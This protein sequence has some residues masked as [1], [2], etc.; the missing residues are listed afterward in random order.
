MGRPPCCDKDSVKKGPWTPEEDILLVSYI[1]QHG[2]SNWRA[3]PAKTGL[4]RC[5]KSCRLRWTNYLRPGIKRGNFTEQ[6]EKLIIHLQALLGNRWAAI[7]SYLPERTDNDIKNYWNTHL[8]KKLQYKLNDTSSEHCVNVGFG[9][10]A[11]HRS[12]PKSKGQWERCLQTNVE[13]AKRALS[14]ALSMEDPMGSSVMKSM[15]YEDSH[16]P[17]I[18][19][20]ANTENISRLLEGWMIKKKKVTSAST[21]IS[22]KSSDNSS[23]SSQMSMS[24]SNCIVSPP[25]LLGLEDYESALEGSPEATAQGPFQMLE[26]WLFDESADGEEQQESFLSMVMDEL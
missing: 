4:L 20:A 24:A 22:P 21:T 14:K 10:P 16:L 11:V 25:T 7:A 13:M 23:T 3:V 1:Q 12:M 9:L 5:S 15:K 8:K 17:S 6:E 2:A 18:T 26:S 19:Y